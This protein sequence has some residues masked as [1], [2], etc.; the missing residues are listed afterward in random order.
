MYKITQSQI[1]YRPH[2]KSQTFENQLKI[3]EHISLIILNSLC[4]RLINLGD[5]TW[6]IQVDSIKKPSLK[7]I[8][9]NI[10]TIFFLK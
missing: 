5:F 10:V 2:S 4:H 8:E 9:C 3:N 7:N 6:F 1:K